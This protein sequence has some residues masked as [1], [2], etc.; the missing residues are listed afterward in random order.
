MGGL[1]AGIGARAVVIDPQHPNRVYAVGGSGAVYRSNDAGQ[2]WAAAGQGLPGGKIA[3][4][5]DRS[6]IG[7]DVARR[8]DADSF[9]CARRGRRILRGFLHG[10]GHRLRHRFRTAARRCRTPRLAYHLPGWAQYDRLDLGTT[11]VDAPAGS[12]HHGVLRR[13]P[14]RAYRVSALSAA[15]A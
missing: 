3:G 2:T 15:P 7:V 13:H 5:S 14:S 6:S 9:E 1:P 12:V 11:E 8:P 4:M 10:L